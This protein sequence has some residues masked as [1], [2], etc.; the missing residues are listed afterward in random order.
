MFFCI[1]MFY[2]GYRI[3][4]LTLKLHPIYAFLLF[5][6]YYFQ[7]WTFISAQV[8]LHCVYRIQYIE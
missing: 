4:L 7:H 2:V 1:E 8:I 5:V 3:F 6:F